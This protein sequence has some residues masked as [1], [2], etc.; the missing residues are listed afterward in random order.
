MSGCRMLVLSACSHCTKLRTE[1]AWILRA[2]M[3]ALW[4]N[5]LAVLPCG[6]FPV[7]SVCTRL[8]MVSRSRTGGVNRG[9]AGDISAAQVMLPSGGSWGISVI[10]C[11][12]KTSSKINGIFRQLNC[13][14]QI[15]LR[16]GP[17][18]RIGVGRCLLLLLLYKLRRQQLIDSRPVMG[19]D[20]QQCCDDLRQLLGKTRR[21]AR[22]LPAQHLAVQLL[23]VIR[24][25]WGAQGCRFVEDTTQAP[26]IRFHI[27]RHVLPDLRTGVVRRP[28]LCVQQSSLRNLGHIEVSQL[29]YTTLAQ[30]DVRAFEIPVKNLQVVQRL[31]A[32]THSNKHDPYIMLPHVR[33]HLLVLDYLLEEVAPVSILGD[34]AQGIRSLI[35]K[36]L[37]IPDDI[38]VRY[39]SHESHL[40]ESID[41]FLF[42]Q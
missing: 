17:R 5:W 23:H 26:D 1:F 33:A 35:K 38:L 30:K 41:L 15:T 27:V 4:T 19:V 28:G 14:Q 29:D 42:I 32:S 36:R 37:L 21:D 24:P 34:N 7:Q 2:G 31:Q 16:A 12:R 11:P 22:I 39:G 25:E 6:Q 13:L 9:S 8:A 3:R 40:I 20:L 18:I 10:P